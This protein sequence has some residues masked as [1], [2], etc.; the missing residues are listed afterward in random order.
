[1]VALAIGV[2]KDGAN[3]SS[4]ASPPGA[5]PTNDDSAPPQA[6]PSADGTS[7][8][9]DEM[10]EGEGVPPD[11]VCYHTAAENCGGCSHMEASGNCTWLKIPVQPGDWC[12]LYEPKGQD[13][14][15]LSG[16]ATGQAAS[17]P[18]G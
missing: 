7:P 2:P 18:P 3:S 5:D 17:D 16:P 1:M 11:A 8:V 10:A 9:D 6:P 15:D 4:P 13:A 14:D 12:K